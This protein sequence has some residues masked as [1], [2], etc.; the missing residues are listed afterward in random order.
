MSSNLLA[1]IENTTLYFD[2]LNVGARFETSGRTVTEGDIVAFAGLSGD[3]NSLHMD[4][5]FATSTPHGQRIAHGLLVLAIV[6]GLSTR[7]PLMKLMEKAILALAGLECKWFKPVFIGD[8]LHVVVEI[9][10]KEQ[11]R[12]PDRGT[13]VMKR[14]AVNQRGETVMESLWRIV[15]KAR[16]A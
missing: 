8:T 2:D 4:A 1:A 10:D 16:P 6:S 13:L 9:V 15:L 14:S 3:F 7:L 11:G 5:E 12:K